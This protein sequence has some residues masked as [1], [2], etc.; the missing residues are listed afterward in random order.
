MN[1]ILNQD[2]N[3]NQ[4]GM[5]HLNKKEQKKSKS[6]KKDVNLLNNNIINN[7]NNNNRIKK[8]SHKSVSVMNTLN[9]SDKNW[10]DEEKISYTDYEMNLLEYN[11]FKNK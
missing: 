2:K 7:F 1:T 3:K 5:I 4:T 9:N 6:K 10:K 8:R 11:D